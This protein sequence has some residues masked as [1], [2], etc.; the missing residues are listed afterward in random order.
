[1]DSERVRGYCP[2]GCGTT[3]FVGEGGHVTCSWRGCPDPGAV[4]KILAERETEHIIHFADDGFDVQHPLR[5][6]IAGELFTC[7]LHQDLRELGG[8][9]VPP[10]RY[11]A[12]RHQ[13][14][15]Y[16]ESYRSPGSLAGWDV[17][18]LPT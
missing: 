12:R 16:S 2:M 8:P 5:E 9:P 15:G 18:R 10:G 14:D 1:M 11:R 3:L 4:D 17:E 13:A 6:R 7:T